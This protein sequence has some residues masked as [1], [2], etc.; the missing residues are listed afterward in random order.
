MVELTLMSNHCNAMSNETGCQ[1]R[2]DIWIVVFTCLYLKK[3]KEK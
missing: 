2:L 3:I 1:C